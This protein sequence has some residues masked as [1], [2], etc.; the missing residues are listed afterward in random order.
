M[1]FFILLS[2]ALS[3]NAFAAAQYTCNDLNKDEGISPIHLEII[4]RSIV[5]IDGTEAKNDPSYAPKF[6]TDYQ[7]FY[8]TND[9]KGTYDSYL[10]QDELLEGKSV[11]YL[12]LQDKN[13]AFDTAKFECTKL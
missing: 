8:L 12:K 2:L 6:N 5:Q 7:R 4:A 10:L 1:K 9:P 13:E 11:G 3:A